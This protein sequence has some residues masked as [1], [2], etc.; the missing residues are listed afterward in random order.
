V[1]FDL[2]DDGVVDPSRRRAAWVLGVLV[3]VA[4][5]VAATMVLLLGTSGD[6]HRSALPPATGILPSSGAPTV[7]PATPTTSTP[8]PQTSSTTTAPPTPGTA[9]CPTT[10]PCVLAGDSGQAGAALDAYRTAHQL[11]VVP[12]TVSD[13]AQACA[14]NSGDGPACSASYFWEPVPTL[15]GAA[16]VAKIA[17]KSSGV[18]WLLDPKATSFAVGWAYAPGSAGKG[19]LIEAVLFKVG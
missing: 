16:L 17:A 8:A 19:G 15:D 11:P 14:V 3:L 18:A 13:Q 4:I 9:S 10:A 7:A 12:T 6:S 1:S 2:P 5:I